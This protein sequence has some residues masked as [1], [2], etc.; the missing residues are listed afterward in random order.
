MK[1]TFRKAKISLLISCLVL[2]MAAH[3]S[4]AQGTLEFTVNATNSLSAT[5]SLLT[6]NFNSADAT[7]IMSNGAFSRYEVSCLATLLDDGKNYTFDGFFFRVGNPGNAL[8]FSFTNS[9]TANLLNLN[10][11]YFPTNAFPDHSFAAAMVT[12]GDSSF[13]SNTKSFLLNGISEQISSYSLQGVPEPAT[14][15][16]AAACGFGW[17]LC[18]RGKRT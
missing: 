14:L 7:L 4:Q 16:I 5:C 18:H 12:L 10:F 9:T 8:R 17:L 13:A 11:V 15:A 2:L 1:T 6:V 3:Q